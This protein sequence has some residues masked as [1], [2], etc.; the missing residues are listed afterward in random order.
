MRRYAVLLSAVIGVLACWPANV[1]GGVPRLINYQGKLTDALG[2][3]STLESEV[4]FSLYARATG[5]V[6]IWSETQNVIFTDGVFNVLLGAVNPLLPDYFSGHPEIY[7]GV[8]LGTDP[9]MVPR[10]EF[11]SAAYAL[12]SAGFT[13]RGGNVGIGVEDPVS[14]LEVDGAIRFTGD[15]ST[16]A[17][18]PR[19]I[20]TPDTRSGC[21]PA[22]PANTDLYTQTFSTAGDA[23]IVVMA[24]TI[25]NYAGRVDAYLLVD[26]SHRRSTLTSTNSN[27]WKP[28]HINWGGTVGP[29]SHTVSIRSSRADTLGCITEWGSI[30]TIVYE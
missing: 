28:V 6:A 10:Q 8:R 17:R 14:R 20:Y 30:T 18:A 9:E 25:T 15:G 19:V 5:G 11:T 29:G 23:C 26:G 1:R 7:L 13:A 21:P 22:A 24:D 3:P 2:V 27:S 4:T 12:K 16:I